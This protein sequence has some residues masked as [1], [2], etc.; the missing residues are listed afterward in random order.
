M[1]AT[2]LRPEVDLQALQTTDAL[3]GKLREGYIAV[4]AFVGRG[5]MLVKQ[6]QAPEFQV[7][8]PVFHAVLVNGK[9]RVEVFHNIPK[10]YEKGKWKVGFGYS[11]AVPK[12]VTN[13]SKWRVRCYDDSGRLVQQVDVDAKT[14]QQAYDL[15]RE[16][17]PEAEQFSAVKL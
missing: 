7:S 6:G 16:Q 14:K 12:P 15:A 8:H 1:P 13:G 11:I 3:K 9:P 5:Y 17:V 2:K 4:P 10:G